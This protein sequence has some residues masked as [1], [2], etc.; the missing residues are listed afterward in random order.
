MKTTHGGVR[1]LLAIA[2]ASLMAGGAAVAIATPAS[3]SL[4]KFVKPV[5]WAYTDS[6]NKDTSYVDGQGNLPVGSW[7]DADGKHHKSRAYYTF[8]L[9]PFAGKRIKSAGF[10]TAETAANDCTKPRMLEIWRTSPITATTSWQNAPA[11]QQNLG[12]LYGYGCPASYLETDFTE[13]VRQAVSSGQESLTIAVRVPDDAE[14]NVALGRQMRRVPG[15]TIDANSTPNAPTAVTVDGVTCDGSVPLWVRSLTPSVRAFVTDPDVNETGGG[16]PVHP[17]YAVWPEG[18][19]EQKATWQGGWAGYSPTTVYSTIP[20]G[21]LSENGTYVFQVRS[22]DGD[23]VS[24]WSTE[25]RFTVDTVG[26]QQPPVVTSADYPD[27]G[28][29]HGGPGI[30]G[31]FTFTP[32]GATDVAGYR[33]GF[34]D[35]TQYAAVNGPDGSASVVITPSR[36][37][38]HYL[39]VYSIDRAGNYSSQTSYWIYVRS[40]APLVEDLTP[41][42][43]F[44][45]P[46]VLKFLPRMDNVVSYTYQIDEGPEQE[47]AAQAD[48][49]AQITVTPTL[50]GV[51]VRLR[52]TTATG[53]HS[54]WNWHSVMVSTWVTVTSQEFP[55]DGSQGAPV[56]TPG[57]FTFSPGMRGVTEYVYQFNRYQED[58]RPVQTV[59]AGPDGTATV[60]YTAT[61]IGYNSIHVFSRTADGFESEEAGWSFSPASIAP[62]VNSAVYPRDQKGGGPGTT[63]TFTLSP[64]AANVVSYAYT[65]RDEPTRTVQA[66]ADGTATIEW[67]PEVFNSEWGGWNQLTVR[68]YSADGLV[69]DLAYYSFQVDGKE[70]GVTHS[71]STV[72]Q[73]VTLTLT[74]ALANSTAFEYKINDGPLQAIAV[75]P[76]G[77]SAISYTPPGGYYFLVSVRSKTASGTLSGWTWHYVWLD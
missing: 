61:G 35:A 1:R 27:D 48:G 23:D 51:T 58:E 3:A 50:S 11:E 76:E 60:P 73:P 22:S 52:S 26:P 45:D 59:A 75:G 12:P 70:P 31:T 9:R 30:A 7:R 8:D 68:S 37:G 38:P 71:G 67:T 55:L 15:I 28:E 29:W 41:T 53:V 18:Q 57:S 17:E 10:I 33:Y 56:G 64:T 62:T 19:P 34:W 36:D 16:D 49:T 66:G 21:V 72:G 47:I 25:C 42:A 39:V 13:V 4:R 43:L 6:R 14:G 40:T 32:N 74:A 2:A 5:K 24:P 44:P 65:F 46:H 69:S 77:T 20:S 63:G 54:G